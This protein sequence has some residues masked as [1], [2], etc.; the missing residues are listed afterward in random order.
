MEEQIQTILVSELKQNDLYSYSLK[1][2]E[3]KGV[4]ASRQISN[5]KSFQ[6]AFNQYQFNQ[7]AQIFQILK[8]FVDDDDLSIRLT[9]LQTLNIILAHFVK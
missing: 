4:D 5:I 6:L 8:F 3:E 7:N 2:F 1:Q 9:T